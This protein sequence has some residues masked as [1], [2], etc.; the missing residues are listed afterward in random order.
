M[1]IFVTEPEIFESVDFDLYPDIEKVCVDNA[2]APYSSIEAIFVGL[3]FVIDDAFLSRFDNV[4]YI[5]SNT[6]GV[7]HI[8]TSRKISIINL[9][10][11]E[12]LEVS[13]T[14]EFSLALLLSLV[15]KIPFIDQEK[16]TDRKIYRGIQLKGKSMGIFGFGRLGQKMASY[17]DALEINWTSFDK[18]DSSEAKERLL[19]SSDIISIHMPLME[20]TYDFFS[21]NEFRQMRK[22]PYI[23]NTARPQ[24]INKE[25]LLDAIRSDVI[26][27][28]AMDFVSYD[29][30][31]EWDIELQ[32]HAGDKLLLT[33]HIAGNTNESISYTADVVVAKFIAAIKASSR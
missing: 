13:A 24:L 30:D 6:T 29:A 16:T 23:I 14:A 21:F 22:K 17:A 11:K 10:P 1:K 18:G 19:N 33:P 7:D 26:S 2:N 25:A 4:K 8:K 9:D 12:I 27:G 3:K 5:V 20:A 32:K 28:L 31:N 15:R